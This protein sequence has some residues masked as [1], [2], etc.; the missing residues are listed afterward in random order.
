MFLALKM[1]EGNHKPGNAGNLWELEKVK[2]A[3]Y[4]QRFLKKRSP[5]NTL[6]LAPCDLFQTP[7]LQNYRITNMWCFKWPSLWQFVKAAIGRYYSGPVDCPS[8]S[9][10]CHTVSQTILDLENIISTRKLQGKPL[11]CYS[12]FLSVI[13][14]SVFGP[15]DKCSFSWL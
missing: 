6:I 7:D 9:Y 15:G 5:M 10:F 14:S 13:F 2:E 11:K 3:D 8:F 12:H 1:K 4:S